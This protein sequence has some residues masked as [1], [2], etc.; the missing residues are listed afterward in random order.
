MTR[1]PA[2]YAVVKDYDHG[3]LGSNSETLQAEF[4]AWWTNGSGAEVVHYAKTGK[5]STVDA[6]KDGQTG[7]ATSS[8]PSVPT[9][10][11]MST[12]DSP[13]PEHRHRLG[14]PWLR[15]EGA[16]ALVQRR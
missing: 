13:C 9:C 10:R 8:T 2:L 4:K 3:D 16:G 7:Q 12:Q 14:G 11:A 1:P 15:S 6:S 5:K